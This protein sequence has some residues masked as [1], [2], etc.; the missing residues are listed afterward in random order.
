MTTV[1]F[2][3]TERSKRSSSKAEGT[4]VTN[5]QHTGTS[6]GENCHESGVTESSNMS[7]STG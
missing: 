6:K 3:S 1:G 7:E 4:D 2:H 5:G